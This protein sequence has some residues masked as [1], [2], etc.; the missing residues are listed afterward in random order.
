MGG[1]LNGAVL[2]LPLHLDREADQPLQW[3]V[4]AQLRAAIFDGRLA[5]GTR[6]PATRALAAALGISRNVVVAAYDELFAEGYVTGGTGRGPTW[7]SRYRTPAR[8]VVPAPW[9]GGA[10]CVTRHRRPLAC[11]RWRMTSQGRFRSAPASAA[12]D[13]LP[14]EVWRRIWRVAT[15]E[16]P[17]NRYVPTAGDPE[18]REALA[19][20]VGRTRGVACGPDD[21]VITTGAAQAFALIARATVAP[22]EAV[23]FEEPGYPTARNILLEHGARVVPVPV[24]KAYE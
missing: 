20:W 11:P 21:A 10:G 24:G 5:P 2:D 6:L 9:A 23:A 19:R 16:L 18:L 1:K 3:Q 13:L 12:L 4:I 22:G 7:R 17:P 15:E 14:V 8:A